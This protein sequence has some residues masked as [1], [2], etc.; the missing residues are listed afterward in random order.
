M[1]A[2]ST[3]AHTDPHWAHN[4]RADANVEV[5]DET[6]VHSM[7]A[8]EVED[9]WERSRLWN[10]AVEVFPDY[11]EYQEGTTRHIP[12]FVAEAK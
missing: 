4:L 8:R 6:E 7:R 5:R 10:L 3:G 2:S 9:D 12:V 11:A 1:N